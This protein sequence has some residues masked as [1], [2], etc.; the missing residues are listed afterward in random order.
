VQVDAA[1]RGDGEGL[2]REDLPVVADDEEIGGERGEGGD[3]L[4]GVD[5]GGG[6]HGH[7]GGGRR[8]AHRVRRRPPSR[9]GAVGPRHDGHDLVRRGE[10]PAEERQDEGPGSHHHQ[11]QGPVGTGPD[12]IGGGRDVHGEPARQATQ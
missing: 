10:Q 2:P 8:L 5:R 6:Q 7:A 4:G 1:E 3:R 11:P 9:R 12:G